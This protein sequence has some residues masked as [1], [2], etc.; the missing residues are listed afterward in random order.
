M[1]D[2]Q[3][4]IKPRSEDAHPCDKQHI[5][6][7]YIIHYYFDQDSESVLLDLLN[8]YNNYS[9]NL[10]DIIQFV[11]VDDGSPLIF[12]V[13]KYDLNI[14]WL[15]ITD[16]IP[17]N[18]G[19]AR[20]L[21]VTYAKS[22]KV[23][24]ADLDHK[25]PEHTLEKMTKMRNLGNKFYKIW[26]YDIHSELYGRPHPNTFLISRGRF[27]RLY[28]YDEEYSG[29]YGA[30]D[31]RF[32]KFQKYHGSWQRK[33]SKKYYCINRKDIDRESSYHS[34]K[35]DMSRNTPI[36]QRKRNE[37]LYW[38][39]D[40]GHSRIFLNFRWEVVFQHNR[41]SKPTR[42]SRRLWKHLWLFRTLK[43]VFFK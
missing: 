34:L 33:L 30:E 28:G 42:D 26:K 18:Q 24:I 10:L 31:Y 8:E 13:P 22:D 5:C 14:T 35:R 21:G 17:W 23:L 40:S 3:Q 7:T 2:K 43:A 37:L 36:D 29:G 1:S 38:G 41:I 6:L 25:F 11:V 19:G 12:K 32:V 39:R 27:L 4:F 20:N 9:K 15:R 16:N